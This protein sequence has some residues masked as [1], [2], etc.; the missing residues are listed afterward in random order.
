M[1]ILTSPPSPL[2]EGEGEEESFCLTS[3][4]RFI[5]GEGNFNLIPSKGEGRVFVRITPDKLIK[6]S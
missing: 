5:C 2:S 3:L 4:R 1:E 6:R